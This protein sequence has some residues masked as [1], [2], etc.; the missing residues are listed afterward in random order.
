MIQK[1]LERLGTWTG[2]QMIQSGVMQANLTS[3]AKE[4][5]IQIC[6]ESDKHGK[7]SFQ[8]SLGVGGG[9]AERLEENKRSR[10]QELKVSR[11]HYMSSTMMWLFTH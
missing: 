1:E 5:E 3:G 9:S 10:K 2:N 4:E 7:Q 8:R 6:H 11:A